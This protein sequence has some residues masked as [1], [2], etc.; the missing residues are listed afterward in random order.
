VILDILDRCGVLDHEG[1]RKGKE[2]LMRIVAMLTRMIARGT[3]V[4]E[5]DVV[6]GYVNE[7]GNERRS[8]Q[9]ES[10]GDSP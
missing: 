3:E 7:N 6:Y 4:R 9:P 2:L 5:G 8:G 10:P 1:A